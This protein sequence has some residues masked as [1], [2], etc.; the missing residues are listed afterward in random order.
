[1]LLDGF[2][3]FNREALERSAIRQVF[4]NDFIRHPVNHFEEKLSH[5]YYVNM[6]S[7]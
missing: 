3:C 2:I 5:C 7:C 6:L 1:M 4:D